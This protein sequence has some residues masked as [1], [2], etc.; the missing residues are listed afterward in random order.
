MAEQRHGGSDDTWAMLEAQLLADA[1]FAN[2]VNTID[3]EILK[4]QLAQNDPYYLEDITDAAEI[5]YDAF[6]LACQASGVDIYS[7][8]QDEDA[9]DSVGQEIVLA[10]HALRQRL[11]V[12][13]VIA[14]DRGIYVDANEIDGEYQAFV[15]A[16]GEKL[17]GRFTSPAIL[18]L[19]DEA[20][21]LVGDSKRVLPAGIGL[22][23][24]DAL[25]LRE[26]GEAEERFSE[27]SRIIITLGISGMRLEKFHFASE[28][29]NKHT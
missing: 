12:D 3:D 8:N 10:C 9:Y 14:S 20:Y 29:D 4:E 18:R 25:V 2:V 24:S 7:E 5:L 21:F 17:T 19:P 16:P 26:T 22:Q 27:K 28:Q 15:L 13:D 23:L 6:V 1:D 11:G